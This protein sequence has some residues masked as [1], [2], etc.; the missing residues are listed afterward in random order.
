LLR[1]DINLEAVGKMAE[2]REDSSRLQIGTRGRYKQSFLVIGRVRVAWSEGFWNEWFVRFSDG[3]EGWLAEAQGFF[4]ISFAVATP[5][6]LPSLT[7]LRPGS[8]VR[9]ENTS[10]D[11]DDIKQVTYVFA[12]GELP[13][14]APVGTRALS[15]D[16]SHGESDFASLSATFTDPAGS[17]GEVD[18]FLGKYVE[19]QD[20]NFENLRPVRGW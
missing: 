20:F 10:Y 15:I 17:A 5:P 2:L 19:F 3:T 13:F 9:I 11:V 8:S 4:M 12:E 18:V 6:D 14:A 7:K 1:K 16:L